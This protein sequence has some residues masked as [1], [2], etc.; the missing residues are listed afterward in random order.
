MTE[1]RSRAYNYFSYTN[2][3]R[4]IEVEFDDIINIHDCNISNISNLL[5]RYDKSIKLEFK[6]NFLMELIRNRKSNREI[7][8]YRMINEAI[9]EDINPEE[10]KDNEAEYITLSS[11]LFNNDIENLE[12]L[13]KILG[14]LSEIMRIDERILNPTKGGPKQNTNIRVSG[15]GDDVCTLM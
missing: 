4:I 13:S 1:S 2:D 9:N 5:R 8:S 6:I 7:L 15:S 11:K 12:K 3:I 10:N 14:K